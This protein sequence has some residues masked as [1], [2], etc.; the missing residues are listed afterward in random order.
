MRVTTNTFPNSLVLQLNQLI[1]QQTTAQSQVS[2]GLRFQNPADDPAAMSRVLNLQTDNKT[3]AQYQGNINTLQDQAGAVSNVLKS[4]K[5]ISDRAGE[6]ATS[7]DGTTAPQDLQNMAAEV[8][9]LIQQGVGLANEQNQGQYLFSGTIAN[10]APFTV[11][12]DASGFV[13]QVTYQGNDQVSQAQISPTDS[14]SV[15]VA[16]VNNSN[17]G[18]RGLITDSRTGADFFQHLIDLQNDLRSGNTTQINNTDS[19]NLAKD[20]DNILYHVANNGAQQARLTTAA[21]QLTSQSANLTQAISTEADADLAQ[22]IIRLNQTQTA[23]Q[24]ALQSG[25][26]MLR[27]SL[28][29]YLQ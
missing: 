13:N 24:A 22:T 7:A 26:Q 11:T 2:S 27:Q 6:L 8:S 10:A 1:G 20:E 14:M 17:T 5:T 9:Q 16:G 15:Q 4:L 21:A 23:Y 29:N 25:A 18:P 12:T 28:L 3:I 19:V